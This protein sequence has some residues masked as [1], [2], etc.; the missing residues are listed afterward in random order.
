[1]KHRTQFYGLTVALVLLAGLFAGCAPKSATPVVTEAPVAATAYP[2]ATSALTITDTLGR[3]VVFDKMPERIVV[4]GKATALM[5]NTLYLFPEAATKLV[6]IENRS[7]SPDAFIS[8]IDPG[9]ADKLTLEKN[10]G[11]EAIAPAQPDV[12]ILKSS[13]K[14]K[15][16]DPLE[17]IGIKV[18]YLDLETPESFFKDLQTIGALFGN[19]ERADEV[20]AYYQG[21]VSQ[22]TEALKDLKAE[23]KIRVLMLQH[24]I[25][26]NVTSFGVPPAN[27]LQT[28]L[29]ETAGAI[30]VWKDDV[31][32]DGWQTVTV[33]QIAAWNPYG[34]AI[35]DYD[36]GALE[37]IAA[38][39]ADPTWQALEA[40]KENRLVAFPMDYLSWDQPDPRWILGLQWLAANMY[41]QFFSDFDMQAEVTEFYQTL[42]GM[43]ETAITTTVLPLL[44]GTLVIERD[45]D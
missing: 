11:P 10:A 9:Y 14:E 19:T 12:V 26:D 37:A 45:V 34:I 27:W 4:A 3:T 7:Q 6:A 42:Y 35:I 17:A 43:D 30:P 2:V 1:M 18:V 13:V 29:I 15:L 41:P 38:I 31:T 20:T 5:V 28:I 8:V 23:D 40:V 44:K 36:G 21:K 22:V 33:D 16:G 25:E 32:G 24:S 39:Q